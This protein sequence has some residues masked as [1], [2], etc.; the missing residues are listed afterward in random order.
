V[1]QCTLADIYA[2]FKHRLD[3]IDGLRATTA[4]PDKPNFPAAYPRMLQGGTTDFDGDVEYLFEV[5]AIVGLESG[6][7]RAQNEVA[8]YLSPAGRK[9]ISCAIEGDPTLNGTVSYSWIEAIGTPQRLDLAGLTVYGGN[10]RVRV[11]A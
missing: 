3:T 7:N 9:S 5:W 1:R 6:F 11:F 4:E 2:G 8:P 10:L